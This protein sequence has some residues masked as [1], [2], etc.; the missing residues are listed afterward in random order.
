MGSVPISRV[1]GSDSSDVNGRSIDCSGSNPG[2]DDNNSLIS[3]SKSA[4]SK[5]VSIQP[6]KDFNEKVSFIASL[7]TG[8]FCAAMCYWTDR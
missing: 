5:S 7:L 1:G 2:S 4:G 3:F 8:I 6:K